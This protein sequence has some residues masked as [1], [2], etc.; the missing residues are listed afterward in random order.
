[1]LPAPKWATRESSRGGFPRPRRAHSRRAIWIRHVIGRVL[2]ANF[3]P[4]LLAPSSSSSSTTS[5]SFS[6]CAATASLLFPFFFFQLF[7][8]IPLARRASLF[9]SPCSAAL[10]KDS[11]GWASVIHPV[12]APRRI[13][14]LAS[15]FKFTAISA[16]D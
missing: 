2:R 3:P 1:M 10:R 7:R 8:L 13:R 4:L 12:D 5:T 15:L 11:R 6:S 16:D 9:R 14:V